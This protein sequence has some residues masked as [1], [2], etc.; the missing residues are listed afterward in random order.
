MPSIE[1]NFQDIVFNKAIQTY[2]KNSEFTCPHYG[3]SWAC[4]PEAP[5]LEEDVSK[6]SKY[7]LVYVKFNLEEYIE[8]IRAKHSNRKKSHIITSIYR[9]ELVRSQ[10]AE[11]MRECISHLSSEFGDILVLWDGYCKLCEERLNKPCTY[12]DGE[13]CRFP[14]DIRYS[15]EA[16]G[17][18]VS[19]TAKNVGIHVEWPPKTYLY[20]FG[21]ICF[22]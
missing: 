22:K 11:E 4:P 14:E 16:V 5:Y 7:L 21:L 13:A 18:N 19:E 2:C 20:R 17:I 6:Y 12:D 15:M 9:K 8:K 3:H 10:F 1:I